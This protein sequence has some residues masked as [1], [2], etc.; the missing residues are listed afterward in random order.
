MCKRALWL[1]RRTS[2]ANRPRLGGG[3]VMNAHSYWIRRSKRICSGYRHRATSRNVAGSE[4]GSCTVPC[5]KRTEYSAPE[6]TIVSVLYVWGPRWAALRCGVFWDQVYMYCLFLL[7]SFFLLSTT[8]HTVYLPDTDCF[9]CCVFSVLYCSVTLY[10]S[11]LLFFLMCIVLFIFLDFTVS[12]CDVR[13]AT[14]TEGF[15]CFFLI[16]KGNAT[17]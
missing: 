13:A 1:I 10:C 5:V 3:F 7:L 4:H 14:V 11:L 12:A 9:L 2:S 15:P 16:C 6:C 8:W 17:V